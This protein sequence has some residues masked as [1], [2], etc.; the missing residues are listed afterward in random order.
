MA[1]PLVVALEGAEQ[2]LPLADQF[3]LV[4][5]AQPAG[6][7]QVTFDAVP[8]LPSLQVNVALPLFGANVLLSVIGL[9]LLVSVVGAAEQLAVPEDQGSGVVLA[10]HG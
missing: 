4:P 8:Q 5:A 7:V 6:A 2:L 1:D 10:A 3:R 9:P